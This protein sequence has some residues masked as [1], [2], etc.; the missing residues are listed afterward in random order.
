MKNMKR[1]DFYEEDEP[2]E[3]VAAAF[4]AGQVVLTE[5]AA[6]APRGW[7]TS[8]RLPGHANRGDTYRASVASVRPAC[9]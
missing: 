1:G 6:E 4:N 8:F 5:G 9:G 7:N 2:V 3:D